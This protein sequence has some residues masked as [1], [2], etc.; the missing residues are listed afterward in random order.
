MTKLSTFALLGFGNVGR[1]ALYRLLIK[2]GMHRVQR[3]KASAPYGEYFRAPLQN[4]TEKPDGQWPWLTVPLFFGWMELP[5][6]DAPPQWRKNPISGGPELSLEPWWKIP[7]FNPHTGDIKYIWE[8][9]RFE[10]AVS[11]ALSATQVDDKATEKLNNWMADWWKNNPPY[12]GPNW[13][14]AQEA[15]IRVLRLLLAA[16]LLGQFD[17]ANRALVD[18][19]AIH[20]RRILPTLSYAKGQ[21]NN[22]ETSEA[23]ALWAGGLFLKAH[24]H[25]LGE[26]AATGKKALESAIMRLILA[27]GTFS[28]NSTNYHRFMLDTV[29]VAEILRHSLDGEALSSPAQT[30]LQLAITWLEQMTDPETGQPVNLGHNDAAYL[31]P[32]KQGQ[33]RDFRMTLGISSALFSGEI[34]HQ[35][36]PVIEPLCNRL[37][38]PMPQKSAKQPGSRFFP[39]GG[40][41]ALVSGK[42]K[43]ILRL[44]RYLFRPAHC[45]GLHLDFWIGSKNIFRD[46]GTASYIAPANGLPD[47]SLTRHHNTIQFDNDEQMPRLSRFLWG[48][49]LKPS[50]PPRVKTGVEISTASSEYKDGKRRHHLRKVRLAPNSLEVGDSVSGQFKTAILRW[51]LLPGQWIKSGESTFESDGVTVEVKANGPLSL[52]M[53]PA[54][55]ALHYGQ[56]SG[57]PCLEAAL[58]GPGTL[59]TTVTWDTR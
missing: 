45:D 57:V 28:Q 27:D 21:Q 47:L 9:S 43:A 6:S 39:E 24:G 38:I 56:T 33:T 14:C 55:E 1:V 12:L 53:V 19:I 31:L 51:H 34:P 23:A 16:K 3:I 49:W 26:V 32:Y 17:T 4:S 50:I 37:G 25:P 59:S 29:C 7:D 20:V 42:A 41:A 18:T 5:S 54:Q 13:K 35:F 15:S 36:C 22:H 11:L 46:A 10:W 2:T 58:K 30:R 52:R 8:S 48:D 40:F 44:P